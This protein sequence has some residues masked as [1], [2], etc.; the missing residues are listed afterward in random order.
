MSQN[1]GNNDPQNKGGN[2]GTT[3]GSTSGT[4]GSGLAGTGRTD[5]GTTRDTTSP[6]GSTGGGLST[7]TGGGATGASTGTA[8]AREGIAGTAQEYGQKIADA[9]STAKDYVSDKISVAGDKF[10]DLQNVDYKQYA[11]EAKNYAREKPGQAILISA[12][13]GFLIG[14]LLKSSNRR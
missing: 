13:A 10:K 7:T 9:A 2:G 6:G 12:A 11:E 14:L 4:G 8:T 1:F 3:G 5:A